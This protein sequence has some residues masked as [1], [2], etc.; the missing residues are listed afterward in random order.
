M[1]CR[2]IIRPLPGDVF[3]TSEQLIED[4]RHRIEKS[5]EHTENIWPVSEISEN[6]GHD[7]VQFPTWD[8]SVDY[9]DRWIQKRIQYFDQKWMSSN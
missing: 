3:L 4:Y 8:E 5:A 9:L 6:C 1:Q 7:P 2:N